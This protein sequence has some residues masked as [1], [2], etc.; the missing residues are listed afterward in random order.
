[1]SGL[2]EYG[3]RQRGAA[4]SLEERTRE[5]DCKRPK[6][7]NRKDDRE[8]ESLSRTE[9]REHRRGRSAGDQSGRRTRQLLASPRKIGL[10]LQLPSV[11]Q[12]EAVLESF[13]SGGVTR[14]LQLAHQF[15]PSAINGSE[16]SRK[17]VALCL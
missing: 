9:A 10:E 6:N 15:R 4:R 16:L 14:R 12:C 2:V 7:E 1:L 11:E 13:D 3:R 8:G 17:F 5:A